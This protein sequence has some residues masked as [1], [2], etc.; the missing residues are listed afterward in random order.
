MTN[1]YDDARSI[2]EGLATPRSAMTIGAHP[3]DAEFGAGGTL[4]RW[5]LAGADVTIVVVSDGS[6]GSWDPGASSDSLIEQR[7]NEQRAA[8]DELGANTTIHLGHVD[9]E[10]E[11]TRDLRS[12]LARLIRIHRPDVV[13]SHDPW[14]RYML[15]PDHRAT[16]MA[17]IDAV[18]AARDHLFFP[19]HELPKHRPD[20][21]LLWQADLVDHVEPIDETFDA[22]IAA[23]LHHSS[24]TTTT[25]GDAGSSDEATAA[26]VE[27]LRALAARVGG[28]HHLGLA[29]G[30]KLLRP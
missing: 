2:N 23:L 7:K 1:L 22:K 14:R 15:H 16:G 10:I 17:A 27:R 12:D 25:M 9:G 6:K 30:F 24:Q 11:N 26:F 29:E 28:P 20:A 13:L 8:A 18:V 21:I 5:S 3:D 4:A 19:E